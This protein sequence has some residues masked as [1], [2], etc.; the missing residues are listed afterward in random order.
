MSSRDTRQTKRVLRYYCDHCKKS[1][2]CKQAIVKH[3]QR[4]TRNPNRVCGFCMRMAE[5]DSD[6]I[7]PTVQELIPLFRASYPDMRKRC[8]ECPACTLAAI[9]QSGATRE[10][11]EG[12]IPPHR[13]WSEFDFKKEV[14][15][16]WAD[17]VSDPR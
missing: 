12:G 3:E 7:P 11:D 14:K 17:H 15:A 10:P 9:I 13:D 8:N 1:G 6:Y 16:F 4:C 2:C 5:D